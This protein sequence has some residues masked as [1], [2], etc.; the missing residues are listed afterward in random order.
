MVTSKPSKKAQLFTR[1]LFFVSGNK[2]SVRQV[3]GGVTKRDIKTVLIYGGYM[4]RSSRVIHGSWRL[5]HHHSVG[6]VTT[7]IEWVGIG[8]SLGNLSME[9][10][11]SCGVPRNLST[12]W[13]TIS[14]LKTGRAATSHELSAKDGKV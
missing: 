4:V 10:I 11:L 9:Y 1:Y 7:A 12:I 8:A 5:V 6:G 3:W 14:K 13:D 2:I